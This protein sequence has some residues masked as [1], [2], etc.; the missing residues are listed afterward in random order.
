MK[1]F[2]RRID[3]FTSSPRNAPWLFLTVAIL[4]YGLLFWRHGFYWD[5]LPM[6]WIRYELGPA[7]LTKYFSTARPVWAWVYQLTTFFL[8]REPWV[9][10]VFSI[11]WRW[12]SVVILWQLVR[13]LWPGRE[14][15]AVLAGLLFLLYPGFNLQW[16]AFL[17]TH[18]Y[19]VICIFL[20]SFLLM[21]WAMKSETCYWPLTIP[22]LIFSALNLWMLEFFYFVELIRALV[23]FYI[24][25]ETRQAESLWQT[26]RRACLHWSPYLIFF[27]SNVL[28]RSFVF[29]NVA[30]QNKLLVDLRANPLDATLE[31]IKNIGADIWV[32]FGQAWGTIFLFPRITLDGPLTTAMYVAVVLAVAALV[33]IFFLHARNDHSNQQAVYWAIGIGLIAM[34]LGGGPYWLAQLDVV[35]AF[36]ASRFTLSFMFGLSL[37]M[38]GVFELIPAQIRVALIILVTSL[39]AGRQALIGDAYLRDWQS[40]KN[41]FWQMSW[42]IPGLKSDTLVLMNEELSFYA[43]NSLA[44]ALNWMYDPHGSADDINF[45]LFY[46]TNRLG[47]SLPALQPNLPIRFNFIAGEFNGN[48]SQMVAIYY[49]PPGCV[50]V[51][52]PE[53]DTLNHFL[54][55]ETLMRDAAALSSSEWILSEKTATPPSVYGPEPAHGWCYYFERADLARQLKDWDEAVRLGEIA[56]A[57]A[58]HPNDPTERYV[59]I[60]AYAHV[61]D[62]ERALELSDDS[63]QVSREF[64]RPS[65]CALWARIGRQTDASVAQDRAVTDA[66]QKF[67]CK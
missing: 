61:G 28:Y 7:A 34:L 66:M 51:L 27:I 56:F 65:L 48:T 44:A 59:F 63:F 47:G 10:Q 39:A 62:W 40:Q 42:R 49:N 4:A 50:H 23:I 8:P 9:W 46:P 6:T 41:L 13:E 36:P 33:T 43:D 24:L 5:D 16:A 64:V 11:L 35:L 45:A 29:T 22:A 53:I 26:M 12:L 31:L 57:L 37:F 15:M 30:Y 1:S 18:F 20:Y 14:K 52:D 25:F 21:F 2:F 55:I 60:E 54:P 3:S 32:V 19:I 67:G 38:A 17:T 58:D